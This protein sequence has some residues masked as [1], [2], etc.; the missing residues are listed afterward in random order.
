MHSLAQLEL[1]TPT[2]L[3]MFGADDAHLREWE[4][5]KKLEGAGELQRIGHAIFA[6]LVRQCGTR[7]R[8]ISA[9]LVWET[10]RFHH[11]WLV[12]WR[13]EN[14]VAVK[15]GFRLNNNFTAYFARDLVRHR[16]DWQPWIELREVGRKP[17]VERVTITREKILRP[18][19]ERKNLTTEGHR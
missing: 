2:P 5:F 9:K 15:P 13:K 19:R 3:A 11:A 8:Q 14:G 12:K 10:L 16:P 1:P 6:G 4:E 7:R 18:C 17:P